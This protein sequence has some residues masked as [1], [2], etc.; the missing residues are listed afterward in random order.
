[1][2]REEIVKVFWSWQA[3]RSPRLHKFL[4]R[5]ALQ[6]AIDRIVEA[7]E[8]EPAERPEVDHDTLNEPGSPEIAR[9]IHRKIRG[10][11][12]FVADM[13]PIAMTN[14]GMLRPNTPADKL[15]SPKHVQNP[16]VMIELGYAHHSIGQG[17]I[18]LI[19][20]A[21]HYPG[22]DALPF[23]WRHRRGPLTYRLEEG[24]TTEEIS[25]VRTRLAD[26]IVQ[27]LP[28]MLAVAAA[29]LPPPPPILSRTSS[30]TDAAI[31]KG[32]EAGVRY[33][34][35]SI[36]QDWKTAH[37]ADG[38]R[39]YVRVGIEN[40]PGM[41]RQALGQRMI[42][43]DVRLW[44]GGGYG[45]S[46]L[47]EN[48]AFAASQI[49]ETDPDVFVAKGFTQWFAEDGEVWAVDRASFW[50]DGDQWY[51]AAQT[52]F[53]YIASLI[54]NAIRAMRGTVPMGRIEIELGA[55]GLLG[56]SMTTGVR[57]DRTPAL[58]DR[59][60]VRDIDTTWTYARRNALLLA[61]WNRLVDAY[62]RPSAPTL[63][64]FEHM[65]AVSLTRDSEES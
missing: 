64:A 61:F 15:P 58:A 60:S 63:E 49:V 19:A 42:S 34:E 14:P 11:A 57:T 7:D 48:G 1:M 41:T 28:A 5:D 35:S 9:V 31:W 6:D 53:A 4:V 59:V 52:P 13:T 29:D 32:G 46:G 16:N 10:A 43:S 17:R 8:V 65:A 62:G 18:L 33:N 51:F 36:H 24:A 23:D 50:Q 37:L 2:G 25:R 44:I 3:D 47:N 26:E 38:P 56:S 20:N 21:A 54:D 39:L 40:W 22:P 30:E 45:S 27:I 55:S 12:V